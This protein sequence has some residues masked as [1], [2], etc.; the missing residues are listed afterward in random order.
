MEERAFLDD[1]FRRLIDAVR[2]DD[3]L[4][5]QI[6]EARDIWRNSRDRGGKV[7]FI[8][9]GG[10]A[11]IASHLAI[12]LTKNAGV[13]ALCFNDSAT[14]TCLA[15]D[16]GYENWMA[17][18]VRLYAN[19]ADCLVAIS[20]SGKSPNILNA[21]TQA[22]NGGMQVVTLSGIAPDNPL[23]ST[24]HLNFWVDSRAY[25]IIETAHQFLL[26]SVVDLIIGKAEYPAS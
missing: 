16:Y 15:N 14:I 4:A 5:H 23:R 3:R 10:S 8:G 18:A 25:N 9:N 20:S 22:R 2:L 19:P 12:D 13:P 1:Y 6:I 24:G 7:F 21:V 26:M 17:H 11:A